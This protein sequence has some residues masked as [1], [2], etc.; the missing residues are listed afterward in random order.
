M[1]TLS[2]KAIQPMEPSVLASVAFYTLPSPHIWPAIRNSSL[3]LFDC[4]VGAPLNPGRN[5]QGQSPLLLLLPQCR[6]QALQEA[7]RLR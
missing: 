1:R 4:K 3:S 5:E 6:K 2:P 7:Q